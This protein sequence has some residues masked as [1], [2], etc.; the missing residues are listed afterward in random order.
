MPRDW[1]SHLQPDAAAGSGA[2]RGR[3]T[4][5]R[6]GRSRVLIESLEAIYY[7]S[8]TAP[9]SL[10]SSAFNNVLAQVSLVGGTSLDQS[11]PLSLSAGDT[12]Q[13]IGWAPST[14]VGF[15]VLQAEFHGVVNVTSSSVSVTGAA[16]GA[17]TASAFNTSY[18]LA[19][20]TTTTRWTW[21]TPLDM[22]AYVIQFHNSIS[23]TTGPLSGSDFALNT[24]VL[25]G[26]ANG[27][28]L[29][30]V[31]DLG[32]L[33]TNYGQ[34]SGVTWQPGDFN[35]DGL[36]NIADLG[37]LATSY[38]RSVGPPPAASPSAPSGL[39]AAANGS[40][41]ITL[42]WQSNSPDAQFQVQRSTD[43][44]NFTTVATLDAG[45]TSYQDTGLTAKTNYAYQVVSI[46]PAN[47]ILPSA[48]SEVIW[49]QTPALTLIASEMF[50]G[51]GDI[52]AANPGI[53]DPGSVSG[54]LVKSI[55]GPKLAG[56]TD[57]GW[58]GDMV[59]TRGFNGTRTL[60]VGSRVM[61]GGIFYF[62]TNPQGGQAV[63]LLSIAAY[64]AQNPLSANFNSDGTVTF[65]GYNA[66][67]ASFTPAKLTPYYISLAIDKTTA[68]DAE[69]R[70]W[71]APL[72]DLIAGNPLTLGYSVDNI[73][74]RSGSAV[75]S[76]ST[77]ISSLAHNALRI[78]ALRVYTFDNISDCA[79]FPSDLVV[80]H[81]TT[82]PS[83]YVVPTG[84]NNPAAGTASDPWDVT[85]LLDAASRC[86]II[87]MPS[88]SGSGYGS[89]VTLDATTAP[90]TA[91]VVISGAQFQGLHV[92]ASNASGQPTFSGFQSMD[93]VS[94]GL[95]ISAWSLATGSTYRYNSGAASQAASGGVVDALF[96]DPSGSIYD[97]ANIIGLTHV[98]APDEATAAPLVDA[99][100]TGAYWIAPDGSDV[101]VR[102]PD[103]AMPVSSQIYLTD[104][105]VGLGVGTTDSLVENVWVHGAAGVAYDDNQIWVGASI[106][107]AGW[108]A[109]HAT[110]L[111]CKATYYG[112]HG[113]MT[114]LA[115]SNATITADGVEVEYGP[116][117]G[118]GS[119]TAYVYYMDNTAGT[120]LGNHI[121]YKNS[122][123]NYTNWNTDGT[124]GGNN[125]SSAAMP[126]VI[127]SHY[128]GNANPF[129]TVTYANNTLAIPTNGA[130]DGSAAVS[131]DAPIVDCSNQ[132]NITVY[133]PT[134]YS[135]TTP[136]ATF[137]G[138][139][140]NVTI[141]PPPVT[142]SLT[143]IA[144]TSVV[145]NWT[146]VAAPLGLGAT[147]YQF[148]YSTDNTTWIDIGSATG[149]LTATA[150]GL[151]P[152]TRYFFRVN[153]TDL[154]TNL[155]TSLIVETTT[156]QD[157]Q[158]GPP[159]FASASF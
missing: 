120:S 144:T 76:V 2:Y 106:T 70:A 26:D 93:D 43:G 8:S 20:D 61:Y 56:D 16:G 32:L 60:S 77:T 51:L 54:T 1:Q 48:P 142:V 149:D 122:V 119:Q 131:G 68:S 116:P 112:K 19:T 28:G 159:A 133:V 152:D 105:S 66:P 150:T 121:V 95:G 86:G 138:A 99:I 4:P 158:P 64:D 63:Q 15:T 24:S 94:L 35:N 115:T 136:Y 73:D 148:Q 55:W 10:T 34:T 128:A 84:A 85:Q 74:T 137:T 117:Q 23:T 80:S 78:G 29:V 153:T 156:E 59:L 90:F 47:P 151:T 123:C 134:G 107:D 69:Y 140:A 7:L 96:W 71:Y 53:F 39:S 75:Q 14:G 135:I 157:S 145:V 154:D 127:Y 132:Y 6:H 87:G 79:T 81:L 37:I 38:G 3:R 33:A 27:D 114:T 109:G 17:L 108:I 97:P 102:L 50:R 155:A 125:A 124:A 143:E 46:L 11:A 36:V 83:Y 129:A 52:N 30:N 82:P 49:A 126:S 42:Q 113:F 65:A 111:N 92:I 13:G 141:S 100:A 110:W 146:Q 130:S 62:G 67:S 58:M 18:D 101:L 21:N 40:N 89:T 12:L 98:A 31:A 57:I 88:G 91:N 22:D 41:A 72:S 104:P 5:S 103:G 45:V 25:P 139:N 9:F 147:P 44:T 118:Y